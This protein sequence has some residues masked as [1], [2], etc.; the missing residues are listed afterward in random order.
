MKKLFL[1]CAVALVVLALVACG[2]ETT[3][4]TT[5]ATT[6]AATVE[7][8]PVST[9]AATTTAA[10]ATQTPSVI[11]TAPKTTTAVLYTTQAP[12]TT[13]PAPFEEGIDIFFGDFD[14]MAI[15][16]T[17]N[18]VHGCAFERHHPELRYRWSLVIKMIPS[19]APVQDELITMSDEAIAGVFYG[20]VNEKY[21]WTVIVDGEEIV[22]NEFNIPREGNHIYV[23]MSLGHWTPKEGKNDYDIKLK[24]T[25][26]ETGKIAYWA[27][28]TDPRWVGSLPFDPET[29]PKPIEVVP[30]EKKPD[31]IEPLADGALVPLS[32][33]ES[34]APTET[35]VKAFDGM[36]T[37]KFCSSDYTNPLIFSATNASNI[38]GIS[39]AG[40][41]D[42]ARMPERIPVRFWIY[43]SDTGAEGS[44]NLV[45]EVDISVDDLVKENYKEHYY[46]FPESVD[47]TYYKLVIEDASGAATPKYQFSEIMLYTEKQ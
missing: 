2:G 6:P 7:T 38:V 25:D 45:L 14:Y 42:D 1:L 3:E 40:G 22:I 4:T 12:E 9:V 41:N 20:E 21:V 30:D 18:E 47:Y 28:F 11:T 39:I 37:T 23:R 5:A 35:Y 19:V 17:W 46:A 16:P 34:L 8:T 29:A 36:A 44:W 27:W 26:A 33:P 13:Y 43:G 31:N 32:G 24:I 10:S 15:D